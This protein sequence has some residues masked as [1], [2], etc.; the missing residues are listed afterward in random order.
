MRALVGRHRSRFRLVSI[1]LQSVA[2]PACA[3][4]ARA[5]WGTGLM[6]ARHGDS[7]L[8]APAGMTNVH[9][10]A[11]PTYGAAR[12]SPPATSSVDV[13]SAR[14]PEVVGGSSRCGSGRGFELALGSLFR[15]TEQDVFGVVPRGDEEIGVGFDVRT[16]WR[17]DAGSIFTGEAASGFGPIGPASQ[18]GSL[19]YT[20][21]A[22]T[23]G[24]HFVVRVGPRRTKP[25]EHR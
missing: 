13:E 19:I 5:A 17:R 3:P 18:A 6:S 23:M 2:S 10:Y 14:P 15:T 12:T 1:A 22:C 7:R 24:A 8:R 16:R 21:N 9:E 25:L 11:P 4:N 20:G